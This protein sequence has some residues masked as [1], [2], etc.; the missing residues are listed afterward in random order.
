[1]DTWAFGILFGG[2]ILV[3]IVQG[4]NDQRR[5]RQRR[6]ERSVRSDCCGGL[7]GGCPVCL[8]IALAGAAFFGSWLDGD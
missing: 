4:V 6:P 1:M 2:A 3:G 7:A 5:G 8:V